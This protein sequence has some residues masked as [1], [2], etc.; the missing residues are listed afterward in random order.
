MTK[1]GNEAQY[2]SKQEFR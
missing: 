2:L 1:S